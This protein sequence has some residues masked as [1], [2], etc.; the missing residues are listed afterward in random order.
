MPVFENA[1]AKSDSTWFKLNDNLD[2]VCRE[3]YES[4][5]GRTTGSIVCGND[6]WSDTPTCYSKYYFLKYSFFQD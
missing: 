5:D 1:R 2:Y 4:R 6:G 3:R